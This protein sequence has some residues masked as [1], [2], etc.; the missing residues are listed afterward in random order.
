MIEQLFIRILNM[1]LTGSFVILAVLAIRLLLRRAPKIFS[2]CLWAVVLFRLLCPIS[3]SAAFSPLSILSSPTVEHGMTEYIPKEMVQATQPALAWAPQISPSL[4]PE[5]ENSSKQAAVVN[6]TLRPVQIATMIWL[7]GIFIMALY[8]ILMLAGLKRHLKTAMWERD[9]IYI[10]ETL[11]TPFVIGMVKPKIYLPSSLGSYEREYVLLHEQIHIK[12]LDH[13][14]KIIAFLTLCIYWFNPFVWVAFF[15]SGQDMEMS[16]DE[17]VIRQIGNRMKKEYSASLLSM[18]TGR[19][20]ISG[21]PLAFGEGDTGSRIKNILHYRKP[22]NL[23]VVVAAI[24]CIL[25]AVILL[26]NPNRTNITED[27][28]TAQTYYG[29]VT[30]NA[31]DYGSQKLLVVPGIGEMEIPNAESISTY[32]ERDEQELLLGDLVEITFPEGA[33]VS[34]QETWPGRFSISAESIV[35]KWGGFSLQR[36][37]EDFYQLT[38]PSGAFP[39]L[40]GARAGDM[41]SF[42]HEEPEELAFATSPLESEHSRLIA[43]IPILAAGENEYGNP[44]LT[45]ELSSAQIQEI[46]SGFGLYIRFSLES[47]NADSAGTQAATPAEQ[48][49][50]MMYD[51]ETY[52]FNVRSIARSARMIDSFTS[53]Y[54]SPY[55]A[56]TDL[57]FAEDCIFKVNY[58]MS[59]IGYKEVS[60]DAFA[61]FINEK[62]V[63][64]PCILTFR[65][66]LITEAILESAY[67]NYGICFSEFL[68]RKQSYFYKFLLENEGED[69]FDKYYSLASS[70]TLD[71]ADCEGSEL[72]EVYTGNLGDGDSGIVMFK[73][74]QGRLLD[75]QDAHIARMGWNNIYLGEIWG[76][77]FIMNVSI[78]DR[79]DTG[80]Y[81]YWVYR[82]DEEGG[83]NQFA[84]SIFQF[85][86][87]EAE[88]TPK[89]DDALFHEWADGMG[90]WLENSHLILSTQDGEVR[91]ENIS[92]ADKY[93]YD[94]LNLKDRNP[95]LEG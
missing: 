22:A 89:Y 92:E 42:Y 11:S 31:S 50:G 88:H 43:T 45:M 82:L 78:E 18:A 25:A 41:L 20:I 52:R 35:V 95:D 14:V 83:I 69:A 47:E 5:A 38:F 76:M 60:F 71:I 72:I 46:F 62:W 65:D 15:L 54:D 44:I 27:G 51:E 21:V 79:W 16:C 28:K 34:I 13:M 70:E 67:I 3:F 9:N 7:Y 37:K 75:T 10:T 77:P 32:F 84:G 39:E 61:D 55:D 33:E 26:A 93:N 24:V 49:N 23:A 40:S 19:R 17:A 90:Q 1:S 2:Y 81:G 4:H 8:S 12:R 53:E 68:P 87:P 57:A 48:L 59:G 73:D 91:T 85:T 56:Q 58:Y 63:Y 94:T 29:V 66:G 74:A 6:Q 86:L 30:A 64:H 36:T 80:E